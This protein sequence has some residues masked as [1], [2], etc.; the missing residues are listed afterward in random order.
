MSSRMASDLY[1]PGEARWHALTVL[2]Q[3]EAAVVAWLAQN[4]IY[5]FY[6]IRRKPVTLRGKVIQRAL[7]YLPGYVF[8]RFPGEPVCHRVTA[9]RH[10]TGAVRMADGVTWGI[11]NPHDLTRIH[12]MRDLEDAHA[13]QRREARRI[14]PG[15][16]VTILSGLWGDGQKVEVHQIR[17]GA[18]L[19]EI[20]MAGR[21]VRGEAALEN[22]EKV[23]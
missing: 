21:I 18:V 16:R 2:S 1:E 15:D 12:A 9:H 11:L 6:P 5:A 13:A 4:G 14:K 17:S 22:V 7:R 10:V 19:F 3:K 20:E 8:A 23:G